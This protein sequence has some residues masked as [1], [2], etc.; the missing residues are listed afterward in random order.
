MPK[1]VFK[2]GKSRTP[3]KSFHSNYPTS[4]VLFSSDGFSNSSGVGGGSDG[5]SKY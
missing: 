1:A 5:F 3:I 2:D 4:I